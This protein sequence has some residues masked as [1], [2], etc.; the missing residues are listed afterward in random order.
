M[1]TFIVYFIVV[2]FMLI[3]M[4][5]ILPHGCLRPNSIIGPLTP[6]ALR[7][8]EA[9]LKRAHLIIRSY[10]IQICIL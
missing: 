8:G 6:V 9:I 3:V 4:F 7:W 10:N 1:R 2:I 5:I